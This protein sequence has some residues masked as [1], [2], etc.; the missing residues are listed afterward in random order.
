M[1]AVNINITPE[2]SRYI[3]KLKIPRRCFVPTKWRLFFIHF[4]RPLFVARSAV[5]VVVCMC[6]IAV[7]LMIPW[8]K[9]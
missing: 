1:Q 9:V 4:F 7:L 5:V 6:V 8:D 2:E 3:Y